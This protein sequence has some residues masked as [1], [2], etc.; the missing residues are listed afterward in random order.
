MF[1]L[2]A[3]RGCP[4]STSP[5]APSSY[6]SAARSACADG[7]CCATSSSG[8]HMAGRLVCF[9]PLLRQ[10]QLSGDGKTYGKTLP[11]AQAARINYGFMTNGGGGMRV[12]ETP[13]ARRCSA[14]VNIINILLKA[15]GLYM[16][17]YN[18]FKLITCASLI[19]SFGLFFLVTNH[20]F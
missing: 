15:L 9:S 6:L 16:G 13:A 10:R 11:L 12:F 18:E 17:H 19:H 7:L 20:C 2:E 5:P 1:A 14:K 3:G 4:C 8:I